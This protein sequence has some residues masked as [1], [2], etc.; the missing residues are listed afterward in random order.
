M[1]GTRIIQGKTELCGTGARARGT[2]VFV[3]LLGIP[4]W[5][6]TDRRHFACVNHPPTWPVL[7]LNWPGEISPSTPMS[8]WDPAPPSPQT[9]PGGSF[10][11]SWPL[12]IPSLGCTVIAGNVPS[13]ATC[14]FE[15]RHLVASHWCQH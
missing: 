15:G 10:S 4:L 14:A 11:S 6:S 3:P 8:P 12:P 13:L 2:V 1:G 9:A 7:Q 5:Q